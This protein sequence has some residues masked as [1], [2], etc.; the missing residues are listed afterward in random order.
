MFYAKEFLNDTVEV[1]IE[2]NDE[3]VFCL[4]PDC[5]TEVAVDLSEVFSD[6]IGDM[7]G[8]S[9]VCEEC[10]RKRVAEIKKSLMLSGEIDQ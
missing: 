2:L 10:S 1:K 8:T 4:C 3:N 6:G 5:G 9:V 7:Y